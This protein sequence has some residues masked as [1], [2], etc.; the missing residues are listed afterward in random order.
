MDWR[1][2]PKIKLLWAFVLLGIA[3]CCWFKC[4]GTLTGKDNLDGIIGVVFGLYMCSHPAA[5]MVDLIFYRQGIW[6]QLS[7]N[8]FIV[9]WLTLN[10]LV[11]LIGW[12]VIFVGT[13]QLIGRADGVSGK[14]KFL[15][16]NRTDYKIAITQ[17]A[18]AIEKKEPSGLAEGM[19]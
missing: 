14:L 11:L 4:F 8:R 6:N 1:K 19:K 15:L 13:T 9:L 3:Y 12:L 10:I 2:C 17:K 5:L 7:S 18:K 16:P